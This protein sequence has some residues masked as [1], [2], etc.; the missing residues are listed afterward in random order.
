MPTRIAAG[1]WTL[2]ADGMLPIPDSP[3]L[4]LMLD[5]DAV[6]KYARGE[7]WLD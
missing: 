7:R 2:D 1:G 5:M 3:G 6:A 4:G